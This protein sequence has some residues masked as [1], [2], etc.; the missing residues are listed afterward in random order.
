MD[1]EGV[2]WSLMAAYDGLAA[3]IML[4]PEL[5]IAKISAA[6][7]ETLLSGLLVQEGARRESSPLGERGP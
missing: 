5:D 3:Y 1:T 6:F 4:I 2:V 7:V